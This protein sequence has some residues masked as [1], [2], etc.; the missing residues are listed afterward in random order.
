LNQNELPASLWNYLAAINATLE[1][2]DDPAILPQ[3]RKDDSYIMDHILQLRQFKPAQIR[4]IKYCR[5]YLQAVTVSVVTTN[6]GLQLD[7][8]KLA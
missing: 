1:V 6:A 3:K 8:S 4:R 7:M 5:F 2:V